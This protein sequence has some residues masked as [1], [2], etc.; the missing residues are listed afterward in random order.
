MVGD[1]PALYGEV[2]HNKH[3]PLL[4]LHFRFQVTCITGID[5]LTVRIQ[6]FSDWT[7]NLILTSC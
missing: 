2:R 1:V 7:C 6:V 4:P 5:E 3:H